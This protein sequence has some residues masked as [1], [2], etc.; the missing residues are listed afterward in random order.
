MP[1]SVVSFIHYYQ[2][3][4]TL[5]IGYVSGMVYD[6]KNVPERIY[7]AMKNSTSKGSFL[8]KHIKEK[9]PFEKVS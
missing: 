8:N 5:R 2:D 3:T 7:R 1:S 4:G 9:F 6:Y